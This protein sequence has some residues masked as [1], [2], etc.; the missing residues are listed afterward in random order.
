MFG[1]QT[2]GLRPSHLPV[3][4]LLA[5]SIVTLAASVGLWASVVCRTH[6]G[7]V[8]VAAGILAAVSLG[9][10]VA[11]ECARSRSSPDSAP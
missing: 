6:L 8:L 10:A 4:L 11:W 5:A 3:L 7:A 2:G 9:P 1:C